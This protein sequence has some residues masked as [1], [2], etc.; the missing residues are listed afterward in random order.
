V[1]ITN[2]G[3]TIAYS[4]G[5]F[6]RAL[7]PFPA[8]LEI[9]RQAQAAQGTGVQAAAAPAQAAAAPAQAA[10]AAA[11]AQNAKAQAAPQST[12]E[13]VPPQPFHAEAASTP[14]GARP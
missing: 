8:A 7:E 12:G 4:L 13:Q 1:P 6:E 9:V 14:T 10:A 2:Y 5:I 3:L 11:K